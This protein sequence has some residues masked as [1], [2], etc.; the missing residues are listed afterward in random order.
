MKDNQ[1]CIHKKDNYKIVAISDI[2]GHLSIFKALL[3]Q[4]QLGPDDI[5]V[6]LGDFIN[7]GPQNIETLAYMYDLVER[8]NTYILKG[9]HEYF[10]CNYMLGNPPEERF[11]KYLK[12]RHFRTIVHDLVEQSGFDLNDC[13]SMEA[14][15]RISMDNNALDYQ[16]MNTLPAILFIDDLIFVHGG[17]D[18]DID[19]DKDEN[20]LLKFDDYNRL[21]KVNDQTVIVGH[22]PS[23]NLRTKN[24]SNSPYYNNEKNIITIDG[25]LGVMSSGELNALII[26]K[27]NGVRHISHLQQNNFSTQTIIKEH[28]FQNEPLVYINYPDFEVKLLEQGDR[29]SKYRHL[30]SGKDV[31]IFDSLVETIDGQQQVIT[32]YINRF[33]NLSIG[34]TV[35]LVKVYNDCALVKHNDTFGWLWKDQLSL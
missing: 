35:E 21:S 1:R 28:L 22:W 27:Q 7:K 29:L 15:I 31:S 23:S 12:E 2:H 5:L 11:L 26:E 24:K 8:P 33:L 14:L 32:T 17:Y 20:K 25:G 16:F 10:I 3:E 13:P 30:Q 4:C 19:I 18:P 9:N 34:S 6:I